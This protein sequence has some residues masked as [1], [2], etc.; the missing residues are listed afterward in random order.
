MQSAVTNI[1]SGGFKEYF[2]PLLYD[3]QEYGQPSD[4]HEEGHTNFLYEDCK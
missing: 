2:I 1:V 4:V 3:E